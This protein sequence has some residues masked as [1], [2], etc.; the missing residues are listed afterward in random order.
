MCADAFITEVFTDNGKLFLY[1]SGGQRKH[2]SVT[3]NAVA[4]AVILNSLSLL[5]YRAACD[6]IWARFYEK[7]Q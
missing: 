2:N 6:I 4:K 5:Q 1:G 3:L 7:E